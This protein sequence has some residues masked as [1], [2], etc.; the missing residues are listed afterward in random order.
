MK[1]IFILILI[2]CILNAL[3]YITTTVALRNGASEVNPIS[4]YFVSHNL[5]HY[6]KLIGISAL[7][8]YL[9]IRAKMSP[10]SQLTITRLLYGATG[11][12]FIILIWNLVANYLQLQ[13]SSP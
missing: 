3:D 10:K 13:L 1:K 11:L 12:Y 5:L 7:S 9:I 4:N 6:Y 2:L 8:I